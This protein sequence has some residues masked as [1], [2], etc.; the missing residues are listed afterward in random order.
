MVEDKNGKKK[1]EF[2]F[3][4]ANID[5]VETAKAYGIDEDRAVTYVSDEKGTDPVYKSMS[6]M[7]KAISLDEEICSNWKEEIEDYTNKTK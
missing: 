3:M 1:W 6:K 7:A 5:A 4:G 2:V